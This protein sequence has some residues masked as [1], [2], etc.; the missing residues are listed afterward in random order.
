MITKISILGKENST[1]TRLTKDLACYYNTNF[2][3]DYKYLIFGSFEKTPECEDYLKI[4]ND[5]LSLENW[6][7]KS[8]N[9]ILF[10]DTDDFSLYLDVSKKFPK[11]KK[12]K[13]EILSRVLN[14]KFDYYFLINPTDEIISEAN[15]L[16]LN[17]EIFKG[18]YDEIK[19][20]CISFINKSIN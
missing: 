6:L 18:E 19:N 16:K 1:K 14:K 17:I 5:R 13:E 9:K 12:V 8:S 20:K 4:S 15:K 3:L 2:V 11:N 7:L 10:S